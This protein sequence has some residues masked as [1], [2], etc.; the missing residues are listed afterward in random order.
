[1]GQK[2]WRRLADRGLLTF[3]LPK[4]LSPGLPANMTGLRNSDLPCL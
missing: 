3:G 4:R 2:G 1:M